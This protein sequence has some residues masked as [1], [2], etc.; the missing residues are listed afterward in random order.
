MHGYI[1]NI[2]FEVVT[3]HTVTGRMNNYLTR[4]GV[5]MIKGG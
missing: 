4:G 2:P 5:K 3:V 1:T